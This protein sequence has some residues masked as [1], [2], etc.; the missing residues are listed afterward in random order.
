MNTE[1]DINSKYV[2]EDEITKAIGGTGNNGA[3][4]IKNAFVE[5]NQGISNNGRFLKVSNGNVTCE[6]VTIPN[7]YTHPTFPAK[8]NGL[9]KITVNEQGHVTGTSA[10][11]GNDLPN[12]P[13]AK[14]DLTGIKLTDLDDTGFKLSYDQIDGRPTSLKHLDKE[15]FKISV[16]SVRTNDDEAIKLSNMNQDGFSITN[17]MIPASTITFNKLNDNV[18]TTTLDT[19]TKLITSKAVNTKVSSLESSLNAHGH[20]S[21]T[22]DGQISATTNNVTRVLVTDG[23]TIKSTTKIPADKV[24]LSDYS[25]NDH[26]HQYGWID[27]TKRMNPV[28][29]KTALYVNPSIKM[30][31]YV[32]WGQRTFNQ[33]AKTITTIPSEYRPVAE[34][35]VTQTANLGNIFYNDKDNPVIFVD[36]GG[37]VKTMSILN[38][39]D[40]YYQIRVSLTWAYG[41]TPHT[42]Q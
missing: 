29:T 39:N 4:K 34:S 35:R 40:N 31:Q 37:N 20:G 21:I 33:T 27:V 15:G 14:I 9:Y 16:N 24:D 32:D 42:Y 17:N 36:S 3:E 26:T 8:T 22:N 6:A 23:N 30:A 11:S 28:V 41:L 19:S 38:H 10:V 25:T 13:Q 5:K 18:Y 12:I 1:I 7:A 2:S